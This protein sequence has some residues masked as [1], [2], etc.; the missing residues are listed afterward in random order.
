VAMQAKSH[1]IV[2]SLNNLTKV[3]GKTS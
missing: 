1:F 2:F 3:S